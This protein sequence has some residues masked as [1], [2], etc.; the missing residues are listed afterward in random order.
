[1]G[2]PAYLGNASRTGDA[3][4]PPSSPEKLL[5]TKVLRTVV[6]GKIVYEAK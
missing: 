5:A 2:H 6:G 1:M 3:G 4:H